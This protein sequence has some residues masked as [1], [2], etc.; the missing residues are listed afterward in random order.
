M[1]KIRL[2]KFKQQV[3]LYTQNA[4]NFIC[5]RKKLEKVATSNKSLQTTT[6][7]PT[8][9]IAK[10]SLRNFNWADDTLF[11][12]SLLGRNW[13]KTKNFLK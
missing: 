13:L 4:L 2:D 6:Y 12:V 10:K 9:E 11:K 5:E 7:Y 8:L 3:V 1:S